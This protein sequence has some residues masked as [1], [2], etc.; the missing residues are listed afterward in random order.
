MKTANLIFFLCIHFCVLSQ[1]FARINE[2][3]LT[4]DNGVVKRT[5]VL[6]ENNQGMVTK[7]LLLLADSTEF[8]YPWGEGDFSFTVNEKSISGNDKWETLNV[9]IVSNP[10]RSSGAIV[11]QIHKELN[12][13]IAVT[14][15]LYPDLP[16]IRKKIAFTNLS[17]N[18]ISI[19]KLDIERLVL[20][21]AWSG[22]D[23]WVMHDYARQK[24]LGQFIST[25]YDPVVI[26][27]QANKQ[28]GIVLGNEAPGITKRTSAFEKSGLVTIGLT[29]TNQTFP[30]RKWLNP[31]QTWESPL[32]FTSV[33]SQTNDT[34]KTLNTSVNDFIRKHLGVRLNSILHKPGFVYNTWIPFKLDINEKLI[35][36]LID[37]AAE[38]GAK[39]FVIDDGW[40]TN[41]GDWVIDSVKFP[42]GLK[43]VFDYIKAKGMKPGIWISVAAVQSNS[44]VYHEHPEW[45]VRK[46]DGMPVNLQNDYDQMYA[47]RE[48]DV[49]TYSMCMTSGWKD[50]IRDIIV[51]M[52]NEYGL[53]YI[54][55]DFATVTGAYTLNKTRSGCCAAN[56]S[57]KDR[58]ESF[59]EMYQATW[60]L[61]DELHKEAPNL[62]IDC[63]YETMGGLQ[64]IDLDMCK[65][66]EG[67]W[68]SNFHEHAPLGAL[69]VRQI[70]W[71]RSPVIP[72]GTLVIGNQELNDPEFELSLKSLIGAFPIA[73]GDPRKL[74]ANQ[75][76]NIK[77]WSDWMTQMQDKY[78]YM[79]YRQDLPGFGE[80]QEAYWDG[81]QRINTD[82]KSGGI[83]GVFRHGAPYNKRT[84]V[85]NFLDAKSVYQIK[86][87]PDGKLMATMSGAD[88]ASKGFIV[89]LKKKYE[90]AIF[91]V[92]LTKGKNL[93]KH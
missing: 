63:T 57:H 88:L 72:A 35:Y 31:N 5:I 47:D 33:Y 64:L 87:A 90:G 37:A 79:I 66:A 24:S 30:F 25:A 60:Q 13:K 50:Y 92:C 68:L 8:L 39:E 52:V 29:H 75:R 55:A 27:H 93:L 85:V 14:F 78:N 6:G 59:L 58:N 83:V 56:H 70:A 43:P 48:G 9:E 34:Y 7:S 2:K 17:N 44:R 18:E 65:H 42:N 36:E 32:I 77:E 61:F 3:T 49:K 23:C 20:H 22:S 21:E 82:D 26:V 67:N 86:R 16:V 41:Y 12:L 19:E 45:L 53:E 91:E 51:K 84:V 80:P 40:N 28:R 1:P 15:L 11:T 71:W 89:N 10:D 76:A 73:L 46:A 74:T 4:L 62:F 69:R 54:K 38:C 81:F